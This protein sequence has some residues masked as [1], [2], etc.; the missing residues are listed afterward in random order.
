MYIRHFYP[1][2]ETQCVLDTFILLRRHNV[3]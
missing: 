2:A 3:Y 1:V